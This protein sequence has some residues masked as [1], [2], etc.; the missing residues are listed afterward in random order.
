MEFINIPAEIL[1]QLLSLLLLVI[2]SLCVISTFVD[3]NNMNTTENRKENKLSQHTDQPN[4]SE[5]LKK[6]KKKKM[7]SPS[8]G[9]VAAS[10][11]PSLSRRLIGANW[12]NF[13]FTFNKPKEVPNPKIPRHQPGAGQLPTTKTGK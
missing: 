9:K 10:P 2:V 11:Q 13:G 5:V 7:S 1:T 6:K 3:Y 8:D 12:Q 4:S